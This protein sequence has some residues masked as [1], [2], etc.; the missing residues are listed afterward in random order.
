MK[1]SG[2]F[3]SRMYGSPVSGKFQ[4]EG[5]GDV[6]KVTITYKGIYRRD[7]EVSFEVDKVDSNK[8]EGYSDK[9]KYIIKIGNIISGYIDNISS[10]KIMGTYE[11]INPVDDGRIELTYVDD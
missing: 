6:M 1:A 9:Q 10:H 8:Y 2:I 5:D 11:T 3:S 4:M 7:D